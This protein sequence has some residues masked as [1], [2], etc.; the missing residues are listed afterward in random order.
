MRSK[1]EREREAIRMNKRNVMKQKG[2]SKEK[3]RKEA[4]NM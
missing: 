3:K 2:D 1:R 4:Q